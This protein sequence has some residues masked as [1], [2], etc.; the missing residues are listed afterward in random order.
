MKISLGWSRGFAINI[1]GFEIQALNIDK[2]FDNEFDTALN[3]R[4]SKSVIHWYAVD[5]GERRTFV[6]ECFSIFRLGIKGR[7]S[8]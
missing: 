3:R 2:Y 4:S 6:R 7:A 1:A 8:P 5:R